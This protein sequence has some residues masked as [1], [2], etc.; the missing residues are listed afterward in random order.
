MNEKGFFYRNLD[1]ILS[2]LLYLFLLAGLSFGMYFLLR[3]STPEEPRYLQTLFGI[4]FLISLYLFLLTKGMNFVLD[5]DKH[6][7]K[8]N[9]RNVQSVKKQLK[10]K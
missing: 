4:I 3:M 2:I 6:I 10:K 5:I 8:F 7:E 1:I 9:K